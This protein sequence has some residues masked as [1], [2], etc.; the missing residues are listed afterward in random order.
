[1]NIV[2]KS[3]G[4]IKFIY[5]E[6]LINMLSKVSSER[7]DKRAT[8]VEPDQ[9]NPGKWIVDLSPSGGPKIGN[10]DCRSKAIEY[11]LDWLTKNILGGKNVNN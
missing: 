7:I 1:M 10:F 8:Y 4:T 2:L 6:K 3:D 9:D 5:N 11:E